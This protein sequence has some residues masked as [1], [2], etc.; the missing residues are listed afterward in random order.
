M[1]GREFLVYRV[2]INI[3]TLLMP[4]AKVRAGEGLLK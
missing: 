2:G 4:E 3:L 1:K